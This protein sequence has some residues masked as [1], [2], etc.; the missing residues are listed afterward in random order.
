MD[1]LHLVSIK[2]GEAHQAEQ[3]KF[4]SNVNPETKEKKK[5]KPKL[6]QLFH[7]KKDKSLKKK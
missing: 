6:N 7:I 4:D 3:K 1:Y 2:M 5:P